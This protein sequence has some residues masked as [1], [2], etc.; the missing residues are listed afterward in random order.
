M[1]WGQLCVD[2]GLWRV[3]L[4]MLAFPLLYTSLISF[5][6]QVAAGLWAG[7]GASDR[8]SPLCL[9]GASHAY[10]HGCPWVL[11]RWR[12]MRAGGRG[13]VPTC[14]KHPLWAEHLP[15]VVTHLT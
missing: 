6:Y 9:Q 10:P 7:P 12:G 13:R 4:C 5:R 14:V 1:W 2:N 15:C 3:I 11:Q 8:P